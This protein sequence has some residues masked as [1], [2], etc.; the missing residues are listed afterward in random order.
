MSDISVNTLK[1][2]AI[3]TRAGAV[4]KAS[5]LGLNITGNVLQVVH[6]QAQTGVGT[7][8]T[9][10]VGFTGYNTAITPS[11]TSSK[12]LIHFGYHA[13]VSEHTASNWRGALVRLMRV[14]GD[15]VLLND[16]TN[17][18]TAGWFTNADDRFMAYSSASYLDSPNTTSATTYGLECRSNSGNS[19][20]FNNNSYGRG[21]FITLY[22]IA[23]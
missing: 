5:D 9:S 19:I 12:I 1:T 15:T 11:S 4:P 6:T 23:G 17:Y 22:E 14:T 8:S 10:Y 2:S 16:G 3:Q 21:G 7:T 20:D 18:G 13:Y